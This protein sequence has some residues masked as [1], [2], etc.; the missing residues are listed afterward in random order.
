MSRILYQGL[1]L[2]LG[3][4][5]LQDVKARIGDA[6][7]EGRPIWL[8]VGPISLDEFDYPSCAILVGPGIPI[9]LL[10]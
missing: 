4:D 2:E 3:D 7:L 1:S 9:A 6:C 8:E 10:E 5:S